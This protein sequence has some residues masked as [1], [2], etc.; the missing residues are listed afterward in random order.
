MAAHISK[1]A[2][3]H[4]S[5]KLGEQVHVGPFCLI[6]PDVEI[7][8]GTRL[9]SHVIVVGKVRMGEH[10]RVH[11]NAVIGA[12]PQDSNYAGAD[13]SVEIGSYNVIRESVTIHRGVDPHEPTSVGDQ[14]YVMGG[15][16]IAHGCRVEHQVV[17]AN[18]VLLGRHVHVG[19]HATLAG[20]LAVNHFASIGSH[21][22]VAGM[23]RVVHDVPP[24]L[25]AEG[26]PA[27]PRGVNL[28]G[29]RRCGFSPET[30]QAL[31][32]AYRLLFVDHVGVDS[33]RELLRSQRQLLP[34]VN[35]LLGF[36]QLQNEGWQGRSRERR[37][38]A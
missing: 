4:G 10:N 28:V 22:F 15:C 33:V 37:R 24:F 25:V 21:A 26:S 29:L 11:A 34:P 18:N 16:H 38:A 31:E 12:E 2:E 8:D 36:V 19:V 7:G 6:G 3:V 9:D 32:E 14:C 17:M 27:R 23:S 30:L 13:T 5:A 35:Y 1:L 20:G